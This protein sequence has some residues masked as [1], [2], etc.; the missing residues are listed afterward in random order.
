MGTISGAASALLGCAQYGGGMQGGALIGIL[1][2]GTPVPM[3]VA[4]AGGAL[5]AVGCA[6]YLAARSR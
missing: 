4:I 1:A 6:L 2:N 3:A 5:A